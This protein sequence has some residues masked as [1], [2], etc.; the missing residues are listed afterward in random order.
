MPKGPLLL[1]ITGGTGFVGQHVIRAALDAGHSVRALIRN[2]AKRP[3]ISHTNL[4]WHAG[5]LGEDDAAFLRGA[6]IVIHLAGLI[7]ARTRAEFDAVN[8]DAARALAAAAQDQSLARFV[9]VSSM[10]AK[11]PELSD[12]AASKRAG[13][14]AVKAAFK[15]PLCILRAPAVFGPGD[16]ATAPFFKAVKRGILPVPGGRGWASR[17]LSIV[18]A[19]DLAR[20]ITEQAVTGAYDGQTVSPASWPDV[21]WPQFA[22][23]LSEAS[24]RKVRALPLPLSVLYPTAS[25][26]SATSRLMGKGHLTLGKLR[27][28]LYGD[29]SSDDPIQDATSPKDA[30]RATMRFYEAL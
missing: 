10:A 24:E 4:S 3:D 12:Y 8:V 29:W 25:I 17:R 2:P 15:G 14:D 28:F 27:E 6:D 21:T 23:M 9:L 20:N 13:E 16:Q 30:L 18:Y 22:D 7:K 19:P 26:T 1:A 11:A 5:A